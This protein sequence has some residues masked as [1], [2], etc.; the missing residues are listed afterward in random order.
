MR[1]TIVWQ[2]WKI[3]YNRCLDHKPSSALIIR[4]KIWLRLKLYLQEA[5]QAIR[6]EVDLG[7][8][9]LNTAQHRMTA[10]FGED[11]MVYSSRGQVLMLLI[12]PPHVP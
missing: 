4:A 5:W 2:I 12:L 11:S 9:T 7:L 3:H 10:R 6:Q 8:I 1:M